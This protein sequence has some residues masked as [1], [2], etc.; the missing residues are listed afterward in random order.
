MVAN[1]VN[2]IVSAL[3]LLEKLSA[4]A[5]HNIDTAG[6]PESVL[7]QADETLL[8]VTSIALNRFLVQHTGFENSNRPVCIIKA[9]EAYLIYKKLVSCYAMMQL[10][11]HVQKHSIGSLQ[12]LKESLP[13][14]PVR[15]PWTNIGGQLVPLP[16]QQGLVKG[17]KDQT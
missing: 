4:A 12:V 17:I 1:S 7:L 14:A 13:E 11:H 9:R 6:L 2:E 3:R 5:Q 10:V 8:N 15:L 16:A